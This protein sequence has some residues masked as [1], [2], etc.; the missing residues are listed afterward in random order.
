MGI[1]KPA[2]ELH[3]GALARAVQANDGYDFSCGNVQVEVFQC[4]ARVPRVTERHVLKGDSLFHPDRHNRWVWWI[5]DLW[6]QAQEL[7]QISQEKTIGVH[8][9]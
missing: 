4:R 9:A 6:L 7:E 2:E 8:L 5:Q 1:I 3:Q